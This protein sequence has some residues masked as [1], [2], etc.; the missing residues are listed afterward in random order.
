MVVGRLPAPDLR[1]QVVVGQHS[2][3][4]GGEE[5]EQAV[6]DLGEV[7]GFAGAFHRAV[8][9][10]DLKV[11]K[12]DL[13]FEYLFCALRA[14]QQDADAGQQF[15]DAEGFGEVVVGAGIEG[16]NLDAFFGAGGEHQDGNG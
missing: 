5:D 8:D 13:R 2:A 6:F 1:E 11:A 15:G 16:F 4:I 14:P 7:E 3:G 9:A 10:V 12:A